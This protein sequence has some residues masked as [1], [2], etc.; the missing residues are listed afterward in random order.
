MRFSEAEVRGAGALL[1]AIACACIAAHAFESGEWSSGINATFVCLLY[2]ACA[3][4][5]HRKL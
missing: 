1:G 3:V 4:A 5:W 2:G